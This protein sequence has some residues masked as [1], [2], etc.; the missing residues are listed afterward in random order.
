MR[1]T[2]LILLTMP[3]L[4]GGCAEYGAMV[5][6]H[7][8]RAMRGESPLCNTLTRINAV[9]ERLAEATLEAA[10]QAAVAYGE[11]V[12]AYDAEHPVVHVSGTAFGPDGVTFYNGTAQ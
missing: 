1:L 6:A 5:K 9:G 2:K 7:Y 3:L 11:G 8:E 12:A 4:M 10:G